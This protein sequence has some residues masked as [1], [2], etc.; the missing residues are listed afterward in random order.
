MKAKISAVRYFLAQTSPE[1]QI[2]REK[3]INIR[4]FRTKKAREVLDNPFTVDHKCLYVL[5]RIAQWADVV[6]KFKWWLYANDDAVQELANY[7]NGKP[8]K[9][10]GEGSYEPIYYTICL[11]NARVNW[12]KSNSSN[13]PDVE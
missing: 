11:H 12:Q 7:L 6:F 5:D 8:F 2:V 1:L 4:S 10:L 13:S 3:F 9:A